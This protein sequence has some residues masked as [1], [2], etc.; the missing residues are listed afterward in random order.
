M[1]YRSAISDV[2]AVNMYSLYAVIVHVGTLESG[3]YISYLQ[4]HGEVR[5]VLFSLRQADMWCLVVQ[6]GR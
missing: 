4:W 1:V 3:H 5:F 6:G 2:R